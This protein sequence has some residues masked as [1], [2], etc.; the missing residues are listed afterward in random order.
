MSDWRGFRCPECGEPGDCEDGCLA[1]CA[2]CWWEEEPEKS[3]ENEE[4]PNEHGDAGTGE[5]RRKA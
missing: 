3:D 5:V 4:M 2:Y 1:E